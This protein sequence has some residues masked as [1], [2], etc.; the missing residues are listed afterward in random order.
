MMAERLHIIMPSGKPK[1]LP[2]IF[3]YYAHKMEPHDFEL[4]WHVMQQ[5]PEPDPKGVNKCNEALEG[6]T[7]GWVL[8]HADDTMQFPPFFR[9]LAEEIE[10][11]P[12][13]GAFVFGQ[14]RRRGVVLMPNSER[15]RPCGVCG[16]QVVWRRDFLGDNRCD[17]DAGG[18]RCD[19]EFIKRMYEGDPDAFVFVHEVLMTHNSMEW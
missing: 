6:I 10:A 11:H 15:M 5:G 17:Y 9:R 13:A 2:A 18:S 4:R 1:N 12:D 19:G 8:F 14:Q 16:G 3:D 7:A